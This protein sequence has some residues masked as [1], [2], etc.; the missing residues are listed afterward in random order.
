MADMKRWSVYGIKFL[1]KTEKNE[2]KTR[3]E[4]QSRK[5]NKKKNSS[6]SHKKFIYKVH[7]IFSMVVWKLHSKPSIITQ[8]KTQEIQ[9]SIPQTIFHFD[10]YLM[11]WNL[12]LLY[13]NYYLYKKDY[14][15]GIK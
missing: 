2:M 11:F 9:F 6:L 5:T 10:F 8:F 3:V 15:K 7:I 14:W 13:K 1:E 4:R 12:S